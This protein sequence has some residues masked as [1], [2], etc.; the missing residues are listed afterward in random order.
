MTTRRRL[1][2]VEIVGALYLSILKSSE[3]EYFVANLVILY[4]NDSLPA[5][6]RYDGV[7]W[8]YGNDRYK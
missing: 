2:P 5:Y 7:C 8:P 6:S 3:H 1:L 4:H